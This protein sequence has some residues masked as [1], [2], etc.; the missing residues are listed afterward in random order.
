M[1]RKTAQQ[2][3]TE[4]AAAARKRIMAIRLTREPIDI[5][6]IQAYLP[7]SLVDEEEIDMIYDCIG[8]VYDEL[9]KGQ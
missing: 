2:I 7:T 5:V 4:A 6:I 3:T 8:Q 1:K 9:G